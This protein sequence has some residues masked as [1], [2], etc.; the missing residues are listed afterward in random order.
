MVLLPE[1]VLPMLPRLDGKGHVR[2]CIHPCVGIAEGQVA[3]FDVA[4]NGSRKRR[5]ILSVGDRDLGVE[6][7][8]NAL[9]GRAT[10]RGHIDQLGDGHNGPDDGGKIA[11]ELDQLT[12]VEAIDINKIAA[13]AKNDA[14]DRLDEK[15]HEN[16]KKHGA[17]RII[18]VRVLVLCVELAEGEQLAPLL[19]EGLDDG[20][21]REALL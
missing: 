2:E 11:A 7:R 9:D 12:G 8:G 16:A 4:R 10:A 1:P 15:G 5:N 3:K 6:K 19:N 14:H 21:A 18:H 20:D 17:F 13:V